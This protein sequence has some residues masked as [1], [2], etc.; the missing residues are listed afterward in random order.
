MRTS[1]TRLRAVPVVQLVQIGTVLCF[2][3]VMTA[4]GASITPMQPRMHGEISPELPPPVSERITSTDVDYFEEYPLMVPVLGVGPDKVPDTFRA[5]RGNRVHRATDILAPKGT[6]VVAAVPGKILR[7]SENQLGGRTIYMLDLQSQFLYYYAHLD[8]YADKLEVG[9]TVG[10]GHILG[11]V[12]A[13]GNAAGVSHL[14]FQA[15]RFDS[16]RRD[17]WNSDPVDVRPFFR[18]AG[19][20]RSAGR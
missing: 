6:P 2:A 13:T 18:L 7:I 10:Q 8:R 5:P 11:Y 15:M 14:H 16:R 9:Q 19:K 3:F 17:Y 12:G 20:E 1:I 4:C